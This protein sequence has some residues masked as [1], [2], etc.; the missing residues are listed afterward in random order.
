MPVRLLGPSDATVVRALRLRALAE[1]PDAFVTSVD[2]EA[3]SPPPVTEE[4]L[5]AV[6]GAA[7]DA[8]L[9]AFEGDTLV[10]MLSL[11]RETRRK[12][13]HRA[14]VR[15]VFVAKEARGRGHGRALLDLAV[16]RARAGGVEQIHLTV[17]TT[18]HAARSLY[19]KAGFVSAGLYKGAM[20]DGDRY[21]DEE[22]LVLFLG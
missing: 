1:E 8:V 19:A 14:N 3:A 22:A 18:G 2:E 15:G 5:R 9:G 21:I 13:R 6:E 11:L 17:S 4:R 20:K 12:A 7:V 16:G 10:G